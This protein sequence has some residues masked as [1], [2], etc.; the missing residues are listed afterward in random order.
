MCDLVH[1]DSFIEEILQAFRVRYSY[2]T[3]DNFPS[4]Y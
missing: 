1:D 3:I 2:E 4:E